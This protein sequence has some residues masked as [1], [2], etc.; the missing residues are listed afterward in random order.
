MTFDVLTE[1]VRSLEIGSVQTR[2]FDDINKNI[3][4]EIKKVNEKVN[5]EIETVY[6]AA[7]NKNK[8]YRS[9]EMPETGV[10][11][12]I[13]YKPV[14]DGEVEMYIHD[15][16]DW[17]LE[18]YSAGQLGGTLNAANVNVINLNGHSMTTGI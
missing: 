2:L 10:R 8:V 5:K 12:D 11:N 9:S 14:G 6:L 3:H 13:W 18:V 16:A 1:K 17:V 4:D 7:N 15:G